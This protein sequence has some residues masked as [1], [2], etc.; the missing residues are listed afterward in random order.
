MRWKKT[1]SRRA[2]LGG[3]GT[4][5]ALPLFP[6][7]ALRGRAASDPPAE[8]PCRLLF[9]FVPNGYVPASYDPTPIGEDWEAKGILEPLDSVRDDVIVFKGLKA[10][11]FEGGNGPHTR[12]TG[13]FL[14]CR[15]IK[16]VDG[17][18]VMA[19]ISVDQVAANLMGGSTRFRSLELGASS[20][21][22]LGFCEESYSC[23]YL[24]SIS[25]SGPKTPMGKIVDPKVAFD[26]LF[27]GYDPVKTQAELAMR[28]MERSSVL[29]YVLAE[30]KSLR[31]VLG[32]HDAYRLDEYMDGIRELERK[33]SVYPQ[34]CEDYDLPEL[35][36]DM[37]TRA[38]LMADLMVLAFQCDQTRVITFMLDDGFASTVY[39]WLGLGDG[40]HWYTH[41][42]GD[43]AMMAATTLINTW[44]VEQFTAL[45][46]KMRQVPEG[47][48]TLLD[49]SLLVFGN[50]CGECNYHDSK[51]VPTILAGR[52]N[53]AV[54]PGRSIEVPA[55]TPRADLYTAMLHAAGAKIES[56][57]LYGTGPL[58][59]L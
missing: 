32:S 25:W 42:G 35:I 27:E 39:S 36:P 55:G 22:F 6:S 43:E 16:F 17:G 2:F 40:H 52:G 49:H 46:Q 10:A 44:G 7:L 9:Y 12:A 50:S 3:T 53:G 58:G 18:N 47:E 24:Q 34:L 33:V 19:G 54:T 56:F 14:T 59:G 38:A 15:P 13:A 48:G 1:M 31:L 11:G 30:S 57:G 29:D 26:R 23:A 5:L 41:H 8:A 21:N 20:K 51:N 28:E 4:F 37:P 45:V